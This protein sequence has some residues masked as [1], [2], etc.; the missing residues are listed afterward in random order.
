LTNIQIQVMDSKFVNKEIDSES[1]AYLCYMCAER[2]AAHAKSLGLTA[3]I[4]GTQ[5]KFPQPT[6]DKL[7][8]NRWTISHEVAIVEVDGKVLVLDQPQQE[9]ILPSQEDLSLQGGDELRQMD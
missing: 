5:L 6:N 2:L 1:V 3:S 4:A 7:D 9:F 8:K